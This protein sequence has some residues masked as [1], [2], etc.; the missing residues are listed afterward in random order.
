MP[1]V[2]HH[3][4]YRYRPPKSSIWGH[5]LRR[6]PAA[7]AHQL[8]AFF[9]ARAAAQSAFR[10]ASV[11]TSGADEETV[12]RYEA[13]AG[14]SSNHGHIRGVTYE[15][16]EACLAE[17]IKDEAAFRKNDVRLSIWQTFSISKW[18]STKTEALTE[19]ELVAMYDT[20]PHLQTSLTFESMEQFHFVRDA[21]AEVGLC[22]L[23]EKHLKPVRARAAKVVAR[24]V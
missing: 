18:R 10:S 24:G 23:S 7:R 8:I 15:A 1:N 16:S 17:F 11:W 14:A 4:M 12:A 22:Q 9:L 20:W 13:L 6:M 21:L 3:N 5:G 2:R 19:S